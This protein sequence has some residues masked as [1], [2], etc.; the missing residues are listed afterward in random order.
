MATDPDFIARLT[1]LAIEQGGRR[2]PAGTGHRPHTRFDGANDLVTIEQVFAEE[3]E[4]IL[5][6]ESLEAE[7]TV[8]AKERFTG[9]LYAGL[10][11]EFFDGDKLIGSGTVLKVL[12][13]KLQG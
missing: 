10:T 3:K 4:F 1:Y 5:P 11:F 12:N 6:G 9:K 2:T 7:M 13:P 8:I